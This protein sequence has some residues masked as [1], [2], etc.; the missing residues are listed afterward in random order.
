MVKLSFT[1]QQ[2]IALQI[3]TY[4][5]TK[6]TYP[7]RTKGSTFMRFPLVFYLAEY[8]RTD[9][10]I[11]AE[12]IVQQFKIENDVVL[13]TPIGKEIQHHNQLTEM[14]VQR[15]IRIEQ[16]IRLDRQ[17]EYI[18]SDDIFRMARPIMSLRQFSK[19]ALT[20][21]NR[22]VAIESDFLIANMPRNIGIAQLLALGSIER[23]IL[24]DTHTQLF[25]PSKNLSVQQGS[26][27]AQHIKPQIEIISAHAIMLANIQP[28]LALQTS[29]LGV[30]RIGY[31]FDNGIFHSVVTASPTGKATSQQSSEIQAVE[32]YK[33]IRII[34]TQS[35]IIKAAKL[36][37]VESLADGMRKAAKLGNIK[38]DIIYA[39]KAPKHIVIGNNLVTST[40]HYKN[41]S[42][43]TMPITAINDYQ[44][45][46]NFA[47]LVGMTRGGTV[48]STHGMKMVERANNGNMYIKPS[49]TLLTGGGRIAQLFDDTMLAINEGADLSFNTIQLLSRAENSLTIMKA[50]TIDKM[51]RMLNIE[52]RILIAPTPKA[53]QY[54]L[55][56]IQLIKDAKIIH[57]DKITRMVKDVLYHQ[58]D[59][60]TTE[61]RGVLDKRL[62]F[63]RNKSPE[64]DSLILPSDYIYPVSLSSLIV[65]PDGCSQFEWQTQIKHYNK[66]LVITVYDN[67]HHILSKLIMT[68]LRQNWEWYGVTEQDVRLTVHTENGVTTCKAILYNPNAA[69]L[70]V[71]QPADVNGHRSWYAVAEPILAQHHPIPIGENIGLKELPIPIE[72]LIEFINIL[73]L[74][75][76]K[77]FMAFTGQTGMQALSG[78]CA[79]VLEW[80]ELESSA[81]L[82]GDNL[83]Y[84]A[85][86][87]RW[88]RWESEKLMEQAKFDPQLSGNLW[89]E[90]LLE[91][92]I[93][94]MLQHHFDYMPQFKD[95]EKMDEHRNIF[96]SPDN[97]IPFVLD[98]YKG[99]RNRRI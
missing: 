27:V 52:Q 21:T 35:R 1:P 30:Q 93:D 4:R 44:L 95:L 84:Y 67:T 61:Q 69:Y 39:I 28:S 43:Q 89:M 11:S 86:C 71:H 26:I 25:S 72:I 19:F 87:Y 13:S 46:F 94:Y 34:D 63:V 79:V 36:A 92:L 76:A 82:A 78:L 9:N 32:G 53:I 7:M 42:I 88:L 58:G 73:L 98:K 64:T 45:G 59:I 68:N 81:K 62:W 2:D 8:V 22:N 90:Y 33:N 29:W 57:L 60:D 65:A 31:K 70:T 40:K 41:I 50:F 12:R 6:I 55:P 56:R 17:S 23:N 80:V 14:T 47:T 74:M 3:A 66:D 77:F 51:P 49:S 38:S 91:E 85:R 24:C 83:K 75:W 18:R 5:P 20:D 37:V 54:Q 16:Q 96:S 15:F 10:L 99:V 48:I 97:N